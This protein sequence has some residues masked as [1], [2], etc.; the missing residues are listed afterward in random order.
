MKQLQAHTHTHTCLA[1]NINLFIKKMIKI[2][3]KY[4][5]SKKEYNPKREIYYL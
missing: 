4:A 2:K 1:R 3:N 5:T